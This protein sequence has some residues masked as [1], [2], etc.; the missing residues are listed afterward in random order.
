[1]DEDRLHTLF[2][3][4]RRRAIESA[5]SFGNVLQRPAPRR[6]SGALLLTLATAAGVIA[7][8]MLWPR[9]HAPAV[10]AAELMAWRAPT[11]PLLDF[12]PSSGVVPEEEETAR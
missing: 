11:D 3:E 2:T 12:D 7:V 1:M 8:V 9:P 5:P 6:R 10:S 4:R